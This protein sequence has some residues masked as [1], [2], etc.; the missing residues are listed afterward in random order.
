[1][2]NLL[3]FSDPL[4]LGV[5]ISITSIAV[6]ILSVIRSRKA[7][8]KKA[9]AEARARKEDWDRQDKARKEDW[10][11]QDMARQEEVE[12]QNAKEEAEARARKEDWDRQ[13]KVRRETAELDHSVLLN[14]EAII[15][16]SETR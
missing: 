14:K 12:R 13:A 10:D 6:S 2:A 8:K 7:D 11:R 5:Y 3:D 15:P 16:W 4:V 9:E 1:M